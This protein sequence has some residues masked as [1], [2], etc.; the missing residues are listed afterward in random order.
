MK[1]G[2][3]NIGHICTRYQCHRRSGD[4]VAVRVR[5]SHNGLLT[6]KNAG[7]VLNSIRSKTG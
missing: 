1:N 5:S 7:D 2:Q 3:Y 6:F 4:E